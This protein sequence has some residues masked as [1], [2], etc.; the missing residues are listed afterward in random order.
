MAWRI[1]D[2][3][4]KGEIDNRIRGLV[5]GRIWLVDQ[6][7][8]IRLKLRGNCLPDLA[9]T[10]VE[11]HNPHP[12]SP[13]PDLHALVSEQRGLV[14]EMT[15]S[16]KSD[17]A[18]PNHSQA[19]IHLEWFGEDNGRIVIESG[20]FEMNISLPSW[21]MN[22]EDEFKQRQENAKALTSFMDGLIGRIKDLNHPQNKSCDTLDAPAWESFLK[23]SESK[24]NK[25][26]AYI[27]EMLDETNFEQKLSALLDI[28]NRREEDFLFIEENEMTKMARSITRE[29]AQKNS[30]DKPCHPL[31]QDARNLAK[32]LHERL[33]SL[34]SSEEYTHR[35]CELVIKC[36][37]VCAILSD[38]LDYPENS[39]PEIK[40][41]ITSLN[42][43]VEKL[44]EALN[45]S[46]QL[47]ESPLI[48]PTVVTNIQE[49]L[50]S[51]QRQAVEVKNALQST[52]N[53]NDAN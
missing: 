52:S 50:F 51:I 37:R 10:Y 38:A 53:N 30:Q 5:N 3:V 12:K 9:G 14:G 26:M 17:P 25:M 27:D 1:A 41:I 43:A 28:P 40:T 48:E 15:A 35:W 32:E 46:T 21:E 4:I 29:R 36:D 44:Q 34:D 19:T 33:C 16:R 6:S 11:F 22:E 49:R 18:S 20:D 45:T 2:F 23:T 24:T 42:Q 7:S 31:I 47:T 8:P 39:N 13:R